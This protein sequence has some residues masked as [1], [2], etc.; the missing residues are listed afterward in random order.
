[1]LEKLA[2]AQLVTFLSSAV[3]YK[4]IRMELVKPDY[5]VV[6]VIY[7]ALGS[8]DMGV[9]VEVVCVSCITRGFTNLSAILIL[10]KRKLSKRFGCLENGENLTVC[11][12]H[13]FRGLNFKLFESG[14]HNIR[15]S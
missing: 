14:C 10:F 5:Y 12:T 7:H 6:H 4:T 2:A 13:C 9:H 3:F 15:G 1:M 8:V 11:I